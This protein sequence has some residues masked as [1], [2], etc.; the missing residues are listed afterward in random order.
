MR[1]IAR[2]IIHYVGVVVKMHFVA[3]FC[4]S[5][6]ALYLPQTLAVCVRAMFDEPDVK[7]H[8]EVIMNGLRD[9]ADDIER[10][11]MNNE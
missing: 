5:F 11:I 10:L 1:K 9:I 8:L 4:V 3:L 2:E 6:I 7:Y